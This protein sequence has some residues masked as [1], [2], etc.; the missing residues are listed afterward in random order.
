TP[1]ACTKRRGPARSPI[2]PASVHR[3][4]HQKIRKSICIRTNRH[5]RNAWNRSSTTCS[6]R[7]TSTGQ[8]RRRQPDPA[9][10]IVRRWPFAQALGSALALLGVQ[11][12]LL[13]TPRDRGLA[14]LFR[15][16]RGLREYGRQ[17]LAGVDPVAR[18]AAVTIR[19]DDDLTIGG[20]M[21]IG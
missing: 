21:R 15:R 20:D 5:C 16:P 11:T 13:G 2:L 9:T 7:A 3:T 1:R 6:T 17:S 18:L 8:S 14:A 4:N 12:A 10:S 19:E